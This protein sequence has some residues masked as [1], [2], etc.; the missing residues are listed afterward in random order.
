M[1]PPAGKSELRSGFTLVELLVVVAIIGVLVALLLPA[2]QSAREA[3][4]RMQCT[5]NLKQWALGM[6]NYHDVQLV[7]PSAT[8][9][10]PRGVWV[11]VLWPYVEQTALAAAYDYTTHFYLPPNTIGGGSATTANLNGPTGR[12]VKIYYC[13]SDRSNAVNISPADLYFRARGNYHVN[14]GSVAFPS[15]TTNV[16]AW[17]PFGFKDF[18]TNTLP[19]YSRLAEI[20]DGTSNT[21]LVSEQLT[22]LDA[23]ADHR[24][25]IQND[26]WSCTYFSTLLTPNTLSPDVLKSG[27]CTSRPE[28]KM[29]CVVGANSMKAVRS[30]HPNGINAANCDGSVRFVTNNI[31]LATWQAL[32]SM[33]G[34]DQ[35]SDF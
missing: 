11:S 32:G 13:P 7:L 8:K 5:N 33:N 1:L 4:R 26:D 3:A 14:F 20:V 6:H 9:A 21:L 15:A 2:V 17:G 25:D 10:L 19:R 18:V 24:G 22:P 12:T 34:G 35:I 23:D 16:Q 27:F 28:R 31:A 29:P 30:R